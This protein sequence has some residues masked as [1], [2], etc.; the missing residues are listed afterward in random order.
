MAWSVPE[1]LQL[2]MAEE[3]QYRC[4]GFIEAEIERYADDKMD[5]SASQEAS[6]E[7]SDEDEEEDT[8][9]NA[10]GK[11]KRKPRGGRRK[12]MADDGSSLAPSPTHLDPHTSLPLKP[13]D[14]WIRS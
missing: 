2:V 3:V 9:D 12:R 13:N 10:E 5:L 11:V 7:M 1:Q 4:A 14:R 6:H 8:E